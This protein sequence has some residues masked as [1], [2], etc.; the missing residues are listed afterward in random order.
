M[1]GR[2]APVNLP[3]ELLEEIDTLSALERPADQFID[4]ALLSLQQQR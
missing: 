1:S 2:Q 4:M 3:R